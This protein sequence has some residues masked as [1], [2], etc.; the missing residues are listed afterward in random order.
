MF[1][2]MVKQH[3]KRMIDAKISPMVDEVW[4]AFHLKVGVASIY[5]HLTPV[6]NH[7]FH[8]GNFENLT[9]CLPTCST[10]IRHSSHRQKQ[11]F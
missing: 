7:L 11:S 8:C 10:E 2:N 9:N 5:T 1:V 3:Q 6:I 4:P